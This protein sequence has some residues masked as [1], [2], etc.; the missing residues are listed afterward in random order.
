M[1][2]RLTA[3]IK[4][5]E[6]VKLTIIQQFQFLFKAVEFIFLFINYVFVFIL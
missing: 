3:S 1:H 6:K 4:S 2:R 5:E